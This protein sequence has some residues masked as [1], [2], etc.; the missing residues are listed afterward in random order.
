MKTKQKSWK[1]IT[2]A[3]ALATG[4]TAC[5]SPGQEA[6]QAAPQSG[7][8]KNKLTIALDW[9]PNAVHS[10]LYVAEEKG[11]FADEN[12]DVHIQMPSDTNDPLKLAAAGQVD[13]AISYQTQVISARAEDIPV[14]AVAALVRHPLNAIMT[15]Q[16]S[17][18]DSPEKLAGKV[19]GYP[20]IPFNEA[21]VRTAVKEAGG[22]DSG[23]S[24]V[25]IGFD[26]VPALTAKQVDAVV[27]GYI[28]HEQLI[29]EKHGVAVH[30]FQ[31]ESVG[32]P[33]YYELVLVTSDANAED[34]KDAIAA[35]LRATSQAQEY[36]KA[37]KEEA[38]DLLLAKQAQEFPLE[39]DI[40][41][42]SL[43]IL[44]PLMDAGD[45]PFGHQTL[46]SWQTMIDWMKERELISKPLQAEE[47]M[48][49]IAY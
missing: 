31:P 23:L 42:K 5:A 45:Q 29:L 33:D 2:L 47:I 24:F 35:F 25:D 43:D 49:N 10:F 15:R 30:A 12:L 6:P 14:V 9:Y 44:I 17:G 22:D 40:E 41:Q 32:V 36:V 3:A 11:Y 37:H 21:I 34:K 18:L 20:S 13:L 39:E 48:Q 38:L 28:N 46:E 26:I 1:I 19:I 7:D 4:L 27:G 8:E 16:D